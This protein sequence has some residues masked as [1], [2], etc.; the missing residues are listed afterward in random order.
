[1]GPPSARLG[2]V[3]HW[4]V[5][6]FP[7]SAC[8]LDQ[9]C[10][11]AGTDSLLHHPCCQHDGTDELRF[12]MSLRKAVTAMLTP[13]SKLSPRQHITAAMAEACVQLRRLIITA[14]EDHT[15][16]FWDAVYGYKLASLSMH[17]GRGVWC[18]AAV[19]P[20]LL[21]TGGGDGARFLTSGVVRPA[22]IACLLKHA[23]AEDCSKACCFQGIFLFCFFC[24]VVHMIPDNCL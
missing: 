2:C 12:M 21:L 8:Q 7:C 6:R 19:A 14:S 15:C 13:C 1:M 5:R 20:H 11:G 24:Y 3:Q 10:T 9:L 22:A 17:G 18:C 4:S 16:T 23:Q